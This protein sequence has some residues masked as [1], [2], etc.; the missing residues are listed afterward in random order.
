VPAGQTTASFTIGTSAVTATTNVRISASFAGATLNSDTTLWP[1]LAQVS[2]PGNVPGG[3]P[4]TGTVFL[5][6]PAPSGGALVSLTSAN[7]P[8][9]TVPARVTVAAGQTSAT[10]TATTAPVTQ[11]TAV[12]ISASTAG[13][14]VSTNLFLIV[15]S[16]VSSVTLNPSSVTG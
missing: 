1:L 16:A 11:T 15:S 3:T 8:L 13:T 4:A 5:N 9:A 6:G 12:S 7:T 2:F 10:F 14:T